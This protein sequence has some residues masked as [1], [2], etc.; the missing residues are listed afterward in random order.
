MCLGTFRNGLFH[1]FVITFNPFDVHLLTFLSPVDWKARNV[2]WTK[3]VERCPT[4]LR[5]SSWSRTWHS[6][7][8]F[9]QWASSSWQCSQEVRLKLLTKPLHCFPNNK[10]WPAPKLSS[11]LH[12]SELL[13]FCRFLFVLIVFW[14]DLWFCH[15]QEWSAPATADTHPE[16]LDLW[17]SSCRLFVLHFT[18]FLLLTLKL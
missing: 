5:R 10:K 16:F 4:S 14:R 3:S 8:T 17:Y 12:S 2:Y 7:Q 18:Y 9:G 13:S 6:R 11:F 1:L 15:R